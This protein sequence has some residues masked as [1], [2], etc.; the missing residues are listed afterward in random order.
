MNEEKL[1]I[2]KEELDYNM[3]VHKCLLCHNAT[4][5]KA[6]RSIAEAPI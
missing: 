2:I 5:N 3:E 4:C 1:K 6:Y